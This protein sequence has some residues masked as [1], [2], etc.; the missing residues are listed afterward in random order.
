MNKLTLFLLKWYGSRAGLAWFA[1]G[2]LQWVLKNHCTLRTFNEAMV[3]SLPTGIV[4]GSFWC[5]L[6]N[7]W[8]CLSRLGALPIHA[9]SAWLIAIFSSAMFSM[10]MGSGMVQ[11]NVLRPYGTMVHHAVCLTDHHDRWC[12]HNLHPHVTHAMVTSLPVLHHHGWLIMSYGLAC[13]SLTAISLACMPRWCYQY[14]WLLLAMP[15]LG[16][17]YVYHL[18]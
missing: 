14:G 6:D 15:M 17:W 2:C 11:P 13:G 7:T 3:A 4:L 5:R 8:Q 1:I 12:Y 18:S 16:Q 10:L 9:L